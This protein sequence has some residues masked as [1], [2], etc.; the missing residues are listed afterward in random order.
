MQLHVIEISLPFLNNIFGPFWSMYRLINF[1]PSKISTL[2]GPKH[3][4]FFKW[5]SLGWEIILPQ[6]FLTLVF[7]YFVLVWRYF[8]EIRPSCQ[9]KIQYSF[10]LDRH[11]VKPQ[12][13]SVIITLHHIMNFRP[14]PAVFFRDICSAGHLVQIFKK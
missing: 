11:L 2:L 10:I 12:L 14:P 9:L 6:K 13:V 8:I 7:R 4:S 3:R 5:S 1:L